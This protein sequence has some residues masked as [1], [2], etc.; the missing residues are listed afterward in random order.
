MCARVPICV[1]D[2]VS[3]EGEGEEGV[4]IFSFDC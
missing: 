4:G 2:T 1:A 3:I